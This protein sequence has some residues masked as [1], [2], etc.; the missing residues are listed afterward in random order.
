MRQ[1]LF[2]VLITLWVLSAC[3]KNS[4][5]SGLNGS[6]RLIAVYDKNSAIVNLHPPG[7]NMDVVIT[8]LGGNKF[9][10]HTLRNTLTDGTYRQNG[11]EMVFGS[12]SMTK[13]AEDKWGGSFL[14]VLNACSLQPTAPCAPSQISIQGNMMKIVTSLRYDITLARL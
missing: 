6:W 12:F 11:N 9:A 8:F 4:D 14:T 5:T 2:T 3:K 10:G 1:I 13:I 7:S